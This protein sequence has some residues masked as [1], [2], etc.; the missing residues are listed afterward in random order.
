[1]PPGELQW[2]RLWTDI[3]DDD[4]LALLA[5][6]DRWHFVALLCM[7]RRGILDRGDSQ[8]MLDRRVGA[9]LGLGDS[10]RD[11]LRRRLME[12]SLIDKQWQPLAWGKRQFSSDSS[13]SRVQAFR[14][15]KRNAD[16]TFHETVGNVSVTPPDTETDSESESDSDSEKI[17]VGPQ[18]A[19]RKTSPVP[20]SAETGAP[21]ESTL[22]KAL[23]AEARRIFGKSCGGLINRAIRDKGKPWVVELIES[24]RRMDAEQARAYFAAAL[25]PKTRTDASGRTKVAI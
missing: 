9:K 8:E 1:M 21:D 15:R 19:A 25:K 5:F 4:K 3:I 11:A 12:L 2:L 13:T 14:E 7:K 10:D 6:E 24:C 22:D 17:P 18:A 20:Q 23:F 16:E